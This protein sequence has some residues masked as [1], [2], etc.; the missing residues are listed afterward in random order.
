M[1]PFAMLVLCGKG[2]AIAG[3]GLADLVLR[4]FMAGKMMQVI[5]GRNVDTEHAQQN[6]SA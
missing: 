4:I 3:N 5:P 2:R 1:E 6:N